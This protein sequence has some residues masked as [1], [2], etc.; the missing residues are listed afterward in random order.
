MIV[1][2]FLS[3]VQ[4]DDDIL[5]CADCKLIFHAICG[6]NTPYGCKST[7]QKFNKQNIKNLLF[8]CDHCQTIRE[9]ESVS[10]LK[11]EVSQLN[12]TFMTLVDKFSLFEEFKKSYLEI[13]QKNMP[14]SADSK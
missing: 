3:V 6:P 8:L 10:E 9:P 7:V 12:K 14:V 5:K 4:L 13:A 2:N 1:V 11:Q